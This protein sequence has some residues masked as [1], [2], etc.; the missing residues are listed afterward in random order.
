MYEINVSVTGITSLLFNKFIQD[1]LEPK[2]KRQT[3]VTKEKDPK[4]KL[5]IADGKIYTPASHF[6]GMFVNAA[7]NFK[8]RGKG[9]STYSKLAGSA[10]AVLP[11]AIIHKHQEYTIFRTTAVN[12]TTKG[13]MIVDRPMMTT[14][15][16]DFTVRVLDDEFPIEVVK[17]IL[18]YGGTYVGI[19][20][21]RPDRKGKYGKFIVTAFKLVI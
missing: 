18:D 10:I 3:G 21:W 14:W 4:D 16:L 7:K 12:P 1:E 13:R 9:K 2:S 11:A 6:E 20:D 5:Y 19:G 17:E 15:A 8:V